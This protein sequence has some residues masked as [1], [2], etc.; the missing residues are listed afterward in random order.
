MLPPQSPA[1]AGKFPRL[2]NRQAPGGRLLREVVKIKLLI[3]GS[4]AREHAITWKIAQSPKVKEIFVAPGNAGT[5]AIA[6]NVNIA[7]TDISALLQFARDN[8]IGLTVVG[9]E[10]PLSAGITNAF[11]AAGL[12]IYGA[13]KA[14]SRIE[15]SKIFTR[16]LLERHH[17][18]GAWSKGFTDYNQALEFLGAQKAPIV[19]KADGLA[20]GKGVVVAETIA[21]AQA[22]LEDFM[23]KKTLGAAGDTILIE[24]CLIGQ[25]MSLFAFTDGTT[26][27]PM[28]PACDYKRIF[29]GGKGPNTGG[30]GSY[31]PA[32]Y[33]N[34]VM[35]EDIYENIMQPTVTAMRAEGNIYRGTLYCGLMI[36]ADGPRVLEYNARFGDPETQ[37]VLPRLKTDLVDIMRAVTEDRLAECAIEWHTEACVGVVMASSGYPGKYETGFPITGLDAVDDDIMVFHAGTKPGNKLGETLT[38]GGRVLTI[39]ALGTTITEARAKVYTNLPRIHFDGCYYRKDIADIAA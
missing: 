1:G 13:S 27:I 7:A 10:A 5:V 32:P 19:I 8:R 22:A 11:L 33:Y 34:E 35:A 18:P 28:V 4:G 9:P 38:A 14:A 26:L 21:Q 31:S 16:N 20:A 3:I 12:A 37:V 30:M 25:E 24:E 29:D 36:T 15:S 17:I 6:Q 2:V 23:V 39:A